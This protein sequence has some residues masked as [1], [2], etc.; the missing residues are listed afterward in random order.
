MKGAFAAAPPAPDSG[1]T[2]EVCYLIIEKPSWEK[3]LVSPGS[4]FDPAVQRKW[5]SALQFGHIAREWQLQTQSWKFVRLNF[6]P[7]GSGFTEANCY[8]LKFALSAEALEEHIKTHGTLHTGDMRDTLWETLEAVVNLQ[9]FL[10]WTRSDRALE[11]Q[12]YTEAPEAT[13]AGC[14]PCIVA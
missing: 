14:C 9:E 5:N 4:L 3:P 6:P 7:G 2:R 1:H 8:I 12:W 13:K 11:I 10:L